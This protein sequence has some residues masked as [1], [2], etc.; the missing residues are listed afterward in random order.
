MSQQIQTLDYSVNVLRVLLWQYNQADNL[1]GL[2]TLKQ[3]FYDRE[4]RDFW[5]NWQRDV[6]DLRTANDFGITVWSVILN[7][8]LNLETT[9]SPNN[10]AAWGFNTE[11]G[12]SPTSNPITGFANGN[13]ATPA[14]SPLESLTTEHRRLIL[15]IRFFNLTSDVSVVSINRMLSELFPGQSAYVDDGNDMTLTYHFARLDARI[16]FIFEE[17]DILPRPSA[18]SYTVEIP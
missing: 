12:I 5:Q 9:R 15:R 6:F 17:L 10:Y 2:L 14:D 1:R 13:F 3:A 16:R 8:P 4:H 11:V 18:T 7:F